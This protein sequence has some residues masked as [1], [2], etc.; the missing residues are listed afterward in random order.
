MAMS[1]YSYVCMYISSKAQN[2]TKVTNVT[3]V[4]NFTTVT[5]VTNVRNTHKFKMSKFK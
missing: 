5:N 3:N 2:V 1:V 4:T